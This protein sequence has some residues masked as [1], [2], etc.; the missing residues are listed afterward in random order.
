MSYGE[1]IAQG[2]TVYGGG[3]CPSHGDGASGGAP[4]SSHALRWLTKRYQRAREEAVGRWGASGA[5]AVTIGQLVASLRGYGNG[6][7]GTS[8][9]LHC[10]EEGGG[11]MRK[12]SAVECG[13]TLEC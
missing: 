3:R 6:G 8:S 4:A 7:G 12:W 2:F 5:A 13:R 9:L 11:E 10:G 1:P